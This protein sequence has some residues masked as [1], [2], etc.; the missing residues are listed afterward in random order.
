MICLGIGGLLDRMSGPIIAILSKMEY[1][2]ITISSFHEGACS[3]ANFMS[4]QKAPC[5]VN[6]ASLNRHFTNMLP[7]NYLY[8]SLKDS[9][10]YTFGDP[11]VILYMCQN[12]DF[13]QKETYKILGR[14]AF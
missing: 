8:R 10:Q 7:M 12:V 6:H 13:L 14:L 2:D 3:I 4:F 9:F 1:N 11:C 5:S